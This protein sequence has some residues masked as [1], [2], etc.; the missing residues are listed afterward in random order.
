MIRRM[1]ILLALTFIS[2]LGRPTDGFAQ[3]DPPAARS[4]GYPRAPFAI[5]WKTHAY[6][7]S[8]STSI[9]V[10]FA[11]LKTEPRYIVHLPDGTSFLLKTQYQVPNL[12]EKE[13]ASNAEAIR[14]VVQKFAQILTNDRT[15]HY[16]YSEGSALKPVALFVDETQ[17]GKIGYTQLDPL[18]GIFQL[19]N[20]D[21]SSDG[22]YGNSLPAS[23]T[24]VHFEIPENLARAGLKSPGPIDVKGTT[25][26]D[27]LSRVLH[28]VLDSVVFSTIKAFSRNKSDRHELRKT[29]DEIG[30]QIG[31]KTEALGGLGKLNLS[32]SGAI[33]FY[34][35]FNKQTHRFVFRRGIRQ[36]KLSDGVGASLSAKAEASVYRMDSDITYNAEPRAG[37]A[38]IKGETWYPPG[39]PMGSL[40]MDSGRGFQSDGIA[41]GPNAVDIGGAF[42]LNTV[43]KFE[44][45]QRVYSFGLPELSDWLNSIARQFELKNIYS[46]KSGF[47][48]QNRAAQV[49]RCESAFRSTVPLGF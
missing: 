7:E 15:I 41:V 21:K 9:R 19:N 25:I 31:L 43:T 8:E 27:R 42:I 14:I 40:S 13:M 1:L 6:S 32:A 49:I 38:S 10:T 30:L 35:G 17:L 36:D 22:K 46:A 47:K 18:R 26:K 16:A 28:F 4:S 11:G 24:R 48:L 39:L 3:T 37:Y 23:F 2:I 29:W 12:S 34:F 44:E 33:Y 20:D 45:V 5:P